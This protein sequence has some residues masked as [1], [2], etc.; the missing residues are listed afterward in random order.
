MLY[1]VCVVDV[2]KRA[3]QAGGARLMP[4]AGR[5]EPIRLGPRL[6]RKHEGRG[7]VIAMPRPAMP[8]GFDNAG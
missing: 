5:V 1:L 7:R 8:H 2:T 6:V 4:A 3:R